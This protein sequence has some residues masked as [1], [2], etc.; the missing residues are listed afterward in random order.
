[1]GVGAENLLGLIPPGAYWIF[2]YGWF[3]GNV[4]STIIL[5][6]IMIRGLSGLLERQGLFNEGWFT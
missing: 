1:M 5:A 6:P 4:V 2:W 3:L